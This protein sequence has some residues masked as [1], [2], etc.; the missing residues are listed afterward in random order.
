MK[1]KR[2]LL[3]FLTAVLWLSVSLWKSAP[4]D[5]DAATVLTGKTATEIVAAM[6]LGWNLGNTFDATG[7]NRSD[8]YSQEQSWGN[9]IV[10]KDL[11]KAVKANGFSTIRIPVTW[12]RHLSDDGTYT[13]D[14]EFIDRVKT[15]VQYA[16]DEGLYIILNLHHEE[17][18]NDP[19]LAT[20][21][22]AIG[23]ELEAVWSQLAA[24]F[25]EFDQHLIFEAMN[26]PRMAGTTEEWY[27]TQEA[28]AAVNYL[29]QVFVNT[30]RSSQAGYNAERCLMIPGYAAGNS[31]QILEAVSIPTYNGAAVNNIIISVHCYSP[32]AFCGDGDMV[33]FDPEDSACVGDIDTVFSNIQEQFLDYGIPVVIGETSASGK[34]NTAA[35]EKWAYYMGCKAAAYGVP[36]VIWDNGSDTN[37]GG[38]SHAYF[39]RKTN[40]L[41]YPTIIKNMLNGMSSVA[42]GSK[43]T[44]ASSSKTSGYTGGTVIWSDTGG[45]TSSALWDYTY[46][47]LNADASYYYDGR[48]VAIVYTGSGVPNLVVDSPSNGVW[49]IPVS[50]TKTETVSGKKIAYFSA[51]DILTVMKTYGVS[52][53]SDLGTMHVMATGSSNITSYE[54]SIVG[55]S[56]TV[57][58]KANGQSWFVGTKLPADPTFLNMRFAGWYTTKNYRAGTEYSGGTVTADTTVY[59]KFI[60]SGSTAVTVTQQ[61]TQASDETVSDT[62]AATQNK[63][64]D[65]GGAASGESAETGSTDAQTDVIM[66][67]VTDEAGETVTDEAGEAVTKEVVVQP[68]EDALTDGQETEEAKTDASDTETESETE[69]EAGVSQKKKNH[70]G[71]IIVFTAV[72]AAALAGGASVFIIKRRKRHDAS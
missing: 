70:R 19:K 6:G 14:Q 43:R 30:V 53:F 49:W 63:S 68:T 67:N 32:G 34:N 54:I 13:V 26:E 17:W 18:V 64:T 56:P 46:I 29:N 1:G 33:D 2:F 42:W 71:L 27:G 61:T 31:T 47:Y 45:L 62:T 12:Y 9:P 66:E 44:S 28:Y 50:P 39:N 65:G 4:V 15:V 41:L 24:N 69:G 55:G 8:V 58:Y 7:G 3:L 59:A 21:Y 5:A 48:S 38:E 51:S 57:T 20:N 16:Y 22:E 37:S 23:K 60:W 11:I 10:T 52:D 72:L 25:A 40:T 36:L 35:R